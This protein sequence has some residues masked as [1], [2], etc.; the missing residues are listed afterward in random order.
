MIT[1]NESVL[2][3]GPLMITAYASEE[4]LFQGPLMINSQRECNISGPT[5]ITA[6]ESRVF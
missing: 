3:Q 5:A 2:F 1:D 4:H 6:N